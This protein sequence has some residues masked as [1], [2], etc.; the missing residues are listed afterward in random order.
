MDACLEISLPAPLADIG[1][2]D[3]APPADAPPPADAAETRRLRERLAEAEAALSAERDGLGEARKALVAAGEQLDRAR[4]EMVADIE[5]DLPELAMNIARKVLMQEVRA[6]RHEID[7]IVAEAIERLPTARD[8]VVHLNP[9]D[10]AR[11]EAAADAAERP[12]GLRFLAD[13]SVPPAGCV[14]ETSEGVV[15]SS[16]EEHLDEVLDAL[17]SDEE[18]HE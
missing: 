9:A 14:V 2:A 5:R 13:P 6:G 16:I 11:C 1:D 10:L 17:R 3:A 15:E 18:R 12:G 4:R 7:P 8:A